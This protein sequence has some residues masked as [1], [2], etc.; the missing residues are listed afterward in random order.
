VP[1][2]VRPVGG[3]DGGGAVEVAVLA[4]KL[5]AV[6][7]LMLA[8]GDPGPELEAW[9]RRMLAEPSAAKRVVSKVSEASY[10]PILDSMYF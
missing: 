3:W 9:C 7:A 5:R 10:K 8:E 2:T 1:A 6:C 4:A